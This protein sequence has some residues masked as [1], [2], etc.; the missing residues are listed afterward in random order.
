MRTQ[1]LRLHHLLLLSL[2]LFAAAFSPAPTAADDASAPAPDDGDTEFI[3]SSC[4]STL[5]P[6][7][8]FTSLSRYANAVQQNPGQLARVAI[9]VSLSKAHRVASYI[10][11]ITREADYG[12]SGTRAAMALHDCFSN[13]GDAVD[14]IRG[15]LKQMRQIGA[16]GEGSG[17]FLFEMSNVQT[18][19]SAALTDEETCTDGFQDVPECP[20]KADV[21][22]R[23]T[24]VKKFTS[25]ALALVNSYASKGSP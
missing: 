20:V 15:S 6:D 4:N 24:N 10:S 3:R 16:A 23:V 9:G 8:C 18:W 11:N 25:N 14:E 22:N 17:S 13:L 1:H 7:V 19:M 2:F 12:T 5:Y 21:C